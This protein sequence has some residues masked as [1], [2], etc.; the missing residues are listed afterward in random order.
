MPHPH[1]PSWSDMTECSIERKKERNEFH[2]GRND[3]TVWGGTSSHI[4]TLKEL[5][6]LSNVT[7]M[8]EVE[9]KVEKCKQYLEA[10]LDDSKVCNRKTVIR[11]LVL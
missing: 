1:L 7:K 9:E 2:Q 4:N 10:D 5:F 6:P 8:V 3:Q 11:S